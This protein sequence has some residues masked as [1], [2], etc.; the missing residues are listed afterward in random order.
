MPKCD[1]CGND[2]D[3]PLT[4]T[5]DG[6]TYHFDC[7]ECAIHALAPSCAHCGCKIIGH[8][9]EQAGTY[10]CCA[11]C[12]MQE[13]VQGVADRVESASMTTSF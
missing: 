12:A 13:G 1:T 9:V 7:F 4:V 10:Y 5:Q 8:G 11:R 2:Y 3:K 6:R